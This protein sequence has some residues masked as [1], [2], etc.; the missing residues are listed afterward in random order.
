MGCT[1]GLL[2]GSGVDSSSNILQSRRV[3]LVGPKVCVHA[4]QQWICA[5]F[6][7]RLTRTHRASTSERGVPRA[8]PPVVEIAIAV[9]VAEAAH[10]L[11]SQQRARQRRDEGERCC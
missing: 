4:L 2:A 7:V 11:Q 10:Q 1:L 6:T 9:P 3:V 8:E 5:E